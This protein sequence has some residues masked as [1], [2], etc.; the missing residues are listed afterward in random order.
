M[1]PSK[2]TTDS[3]YRF[4]ILQ[5]STT[6]F[7][8]SSQ[9]DK[10][11]VLGKH[12][13]SLAWD[14][15]FEKIDGCTRDRGMG[16]YSKFNGRCSHENFSDN[17]LTNTCIISPATSVQAENII[18]Y[19]GLY[20]LAG[21]KIRRNSRCYVERAPCIYLMYYNYRSIFE[22]NIFHGIRDDWR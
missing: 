20:Y 13:L 2:K 4:Y 17:S 10:K 1:L 18:A 5:Q 7:L 6:E 9:T 21:E 12:S 11:I 8:N 14:Y 19:G 22:G 3:S 15:R 16:N